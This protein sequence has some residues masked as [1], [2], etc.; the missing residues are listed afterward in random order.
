MVRIF[1]S[2]WD[3]KV[4]CRSNKDRNGSM[5]DL[6]IGKE[7]EDMRYFR[8]SY[9]EIF[10]KFYVVCNDSGMVQ[11]YDKG[12]FYTQKEYRRMKLDSLNV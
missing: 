5:C 12:Q 6:T 10:I 2:I 3:M 4:V 1:S 11:S 8:E 7:Y 9:D